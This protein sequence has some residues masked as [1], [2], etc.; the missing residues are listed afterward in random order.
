MG[1]HL[2]I[3]WKCFHLFG[4]VSE[5][6]KKKKQKRTL[7][8]IGFQGVLFKNA[9]T[10]EE[11]KNLTPSDFALGDYDSIVP[12]YMLQGRQNNSCIILQRSQRS[13]FNRTES[14]LLI[15]FSH[16]CSQLNLLEWL[17]L[18]PLMF[19]ISVNIGNLASQLGSPFLLL[20]TGLVITVSLISQRIHVHN[21]VGC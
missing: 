19:I 3:F 18:P 11:I 17:C 14:W 16:K 9:I 13:C 5:R 21:H 1:D 4:K 2:R 6:I 8:F 7:Q 15:S 12:V 20:L 10:L